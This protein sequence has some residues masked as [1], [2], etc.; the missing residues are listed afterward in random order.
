MCT[1][2]SGGRWQYHQRRSIQ[3]VQ[4]TSSRFGR[5]RFGSAGRFLSIRFGRAGL[6][7]AGRF[8]FTASISTACFYAYPVIA[9]AARFN[10]ASVI[11]FSRLGCAGLGSGAG[12]AF[13]G[14]FHAFMFTSVVD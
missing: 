3:H 14:S 4:L 9:A 2:K 10:A 8:L 11:A 13:L 6:G 1:N 7:S 5:A 12:F